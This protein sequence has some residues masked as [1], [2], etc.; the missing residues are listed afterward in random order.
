[1]ILLAGCND[2]TDP[3]VVRPDL[4]PLGRAC[5]KYPLPDYVR[6]MSIP[7]FA[8]QNRKAAIMN[9][10]A[11]GDCQKAWAEVRAAYGSAK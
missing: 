6:G 11:V 7:V 1:M 8:L 5:V 4:P 10:L 3:I 2:K 9:Y